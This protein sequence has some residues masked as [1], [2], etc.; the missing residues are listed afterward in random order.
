MK[1][2]NKHSTSACDALT[3][4]W[5]KALP[6]CEAGVCA[7][8]APPWDWPTWL[9]SSASLSLGMERPSKDRSGCHGSSQLSAQGT[10]VGGS[11][12]EEHVSRCFL[13]SQGSWL[14]EIMQRSHHKKG[15]ARRERE[16]KREGE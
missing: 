15:R 9:S 1:K 6:T 5:R 12:E 10:V 8:K 2:T 14:R 13:A 11:G 7:K 16:R 3:S 4:H